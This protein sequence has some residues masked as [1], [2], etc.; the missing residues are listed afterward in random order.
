MSGKQ[1]AERKSVAFVSIA[2][3]PKFDSEGLQVSKYM[4]YLVRECGQELPLDVVTSRVPTLNMPF[5]ASLLSST[6]GVRQ[7]VELPIFEN[8]YTNYLLRKLWPSLAY[9][10]DSKFTFH[11]QWWRARQKLRQKPGL[12]YSRSFPASSAIMA[13]KL[14][15]HFKV[16]WIFHLSDPWADS[17]HI[18]YGSE[19]A[20]L[21]NQRL[22]RA[23]FEAADVISLTSRRTIGFYQKK[24]ADLEK[25]YE[26]FPNV[27]D[28]DDLTEPEPFTHQGRTKLRLIHTGGL[29][30][31]RSPEPFLR[32]LANLE[33]HYQ[34]RL[35][36]VFAGH[37][38]RQ[39]R[40]ILAKYSSPGLDYLGPLATYQE[41]IRLQQTA[42]VLLLID[43]PVDRE[44]LRVYFLSKLLDYHLTGKPILAITDPGSEC[45][46]FIAGEGSHSFTRPDSAGIAQHL[47]WL[48]DQF[49]QGRPEYFQCRPVRIEYSAAYNAKRLHALFRELL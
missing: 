18:D 3:P 10:P 5:D 32:A 19:R 24:Y 33:P 11:H 9:S 26:F 8:K 12:I 4:K 17:P 14:K 46:A 2:F 6:Q 29:A 16:P 21:F 30:G 36:V 37:V 7:T 23:C 41:A 20:R 47:R 15:K 34:D 27:Y 45:A 28:P 49:S 38:D 31:S 39:N 13:L 44:D 48:I 25:R 42:D 40:A 1:G 43:F 22:E 35:E